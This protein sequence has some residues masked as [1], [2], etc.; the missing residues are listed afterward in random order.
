[1]G[2]GQV[3]L[4]GV[5]LDTMCVKFLLYI[6]EERKLFILLCRPNRFNCFSMPMQPLSPLMRSEDAAHSDDW[7]VAEEGEEGEEG[8]ESEDGDGSDSSG[9]EEVRGMVWF[10]EFKD[11]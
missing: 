4:G 2:S 9:W 10:L 7:G 6:V 3:K 8:S 5:G 11:L 1:M